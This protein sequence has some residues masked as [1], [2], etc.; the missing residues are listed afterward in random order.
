VSRAV[1]CGPLNALVCRLL[2]ASKGASTPFT[3]GINAAV[4]R[5]CARGA[6]LR[7]SYAGDEDAPGFP[8]LFHENGV[9]DCD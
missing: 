2:P 8:R 6:P 9:A 1:M 7:M 5:G 4:H 3:L